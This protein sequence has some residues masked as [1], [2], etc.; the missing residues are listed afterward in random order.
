MSQHNKLIDRA[1]SLGI[2]VTDVSN[3][4]LGPF[5]ILEY[6]GI[7]ELVRDGVPLSFINLRSEYYCDNKQLT[8]T[9][10]EKFNIPCPKSILFQKDNFKHLSQHLIEGKRFVCKPMDGTNGD[11]IR[12]H[13]SNIKHVEDYLSQQSNPKQQFMLEEFVEG[14]DLRIQVLG[15]K[16][17]AACI[18]EAAFVIGNGKDK[19]IELIESRKEQMRIQ[20]PNNHLTIDQSTKGLLIEQKISLYDIPSKNQKIRLKQVSNMAQGGIATDVTDSIHSIFSEWVKQIVDYLK[21]DYFG[22][23]FVSTD[24]SVDPINNTKAL[25]INARAD[26]LHHTFSE[27]KQHDMAYLILDAIFHF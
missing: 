20:N 14:Q 11:S 5:A 25:E 6:N 1:K 15:G 3:M 9:V 21:T 12:M 22:I 18:R 8:K 23:D 10:F 2:R 17:V 13:I 7:S 19:L 24:Y 4:M 26:W 16:I 27:R